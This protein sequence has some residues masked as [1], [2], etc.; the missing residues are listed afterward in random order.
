[1]NRRDNYSVTI[2]LPGRKLLPQIIMALLLIGF[3]SYARTDSL[4]ASHSA[5]TRSEYQSDINPMNIH[6]SS[7]DVYT[8]FVR[9][10][11]PNGL[12][13]SSEGNH[14][15][16]LYDN[17]LAALVFTAHGDYARA[18]RIF[19]F[20][21]KRID[22]EL[23]SG[24]GGFASLRQRSGKPIGG[25]WLG[26]NAWLL[27]AL[28]NYSAKVKSK[29]YDRLKVEMES[30]IRSLQDDDGGLWQ[31]YE[32]NVPVRK[33]TENMIDAFNAVTGYDEFHGKMLRYLKA[34]RWDNERRL[35]ISWPGHA[36]ELALDNITWGYCALE[37]FPVESLNNL[38]V[39]RTIKQSSLTEA[40]ITGF[41]FDV[42][43]DNV[44]YEGTGQAVVALQKAGDYQ[45]ANFYLMEIE[46]GMVNSKQFATPKGIPFVSNHGTGY[47]EDL[48]WDNAATM[49]HVSSAAW[50][51]F[52][53][54]NFDPLSIG[55]YKNIPAA[56][57]FWLQSSKR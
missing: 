30:W 42:D 13:T 55:Y 39:F 36:Y 27:I 51:L 5:I 10:Q 41:C 47:G 28:N 35:L 50:Y 38:T 33:V 22:S 53:L 4:T 2:F 48:L 56:D 18:E 37:D 45:Q 25:R 3:G 44:W 9:M 16:S 7:S 19:N 24:T 23:L 57:K 6:P 46:K 14:K 17:A 21:N 29:K 20:F 1:M 40:M 34:N 49:P 11:L 32:D 54:W 12:L 26:D 52:G 15:V 43:L 31:G 8:W